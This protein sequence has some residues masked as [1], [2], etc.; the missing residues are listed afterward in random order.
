MAND[1]SIPRH[2]GEAEPIPPRRPEAPSRARYAAANPP[3]T[4]RFKVKTYNG[5]VASCERLGIS[6]SKG[7]HRC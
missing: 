6:L 3:H 5:I 2:G 1:T 4:V 7:E